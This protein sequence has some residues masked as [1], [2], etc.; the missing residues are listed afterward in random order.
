MNEVTNFAEMIVKTNL[1]TL[2]EAAK[3]TQ[4]KL[5]QK[6]SKVAESKIDIF[7]NTKSLML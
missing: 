4:E 6:L 2:K 3:L 5:N 7:K 1:L